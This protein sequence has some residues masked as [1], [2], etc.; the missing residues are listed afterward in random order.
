MY[1]IE[2]G[3]YEIRC[4]RK[5]NNYEINGVAKKKYS[6]QYLYDDVNMSYAFTGSM[7][8][9]TDFECLKPSH[10]WLVPKRGNMGKSF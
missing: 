8:V 10:E 3:K 6:G 5:L 2:T 1:N 4:S 9:G 7:T